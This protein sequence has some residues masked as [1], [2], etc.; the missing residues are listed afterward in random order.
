[1]SKRDVGKVL[2]A[3]NYLLPFLIVVLTRVGGGLTEAKL[4][5]IIVLLY[6]IYPTM[7]VL[8]NI[9]ISKLMELTSFL[10]GLLVLSGLLLIDIADILI[11]LFY[12]TSAKIA[13]DRGTINIII[14]RLAYYVFISL[15]YYLIK[16]DDNIIPAG[17]SK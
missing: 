2:I 12:D 10:S 14:V 8:L 16:K 6:I 17:D 3:I 7:I 5:K 9:S 4:I 11:G 15:L 13:F 1:M